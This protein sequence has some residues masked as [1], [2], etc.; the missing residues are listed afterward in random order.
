MNNTY[1]KKLS[2]FLYDN[3]N[4]EEN[5]KENK[6]ESK[7]LTDNEINNKFK[8]RYYFYNFYKLKNI[9]FFNILIYIEA[10]FKVKIDRNKLIDKI[11]NKKLDD[12]KIY[13]ELRKHTNL[14]D[15]VKIEKDLYLIKHINNKI[16]KII[17]TIIKS[18]NNLYREI[19]NNIFKRIL[20]IGTEREE[21]LNK[22]EDIFKCKAL[23]LN[24]DEGYEHY[25]KI[26]DKSRIIIYDGLNFPFFDN[27]FDLVTI[28][29]VLHHIPEDNI[30]IF[31]KNLSKITKRIFISDNNISDENIKKFIEIQH[32]VYEGVLYPNKRS[33][34]NLNFNL[35]ILINEL[36][37]NNF[38]IKI[39]DS[40][41]DHMFGSFNLYA[42]KKI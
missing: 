34:I 38:E 20:D 9:N 40:I 6:K 1:S 36:N 14:D 2:F 35:N 39:I 5:K 13:H 25:E 23:G 29:A 8:N 32:E 42:I 18:N 12:A 11:K 22:L 31:I 41:K 33:F 26:K 28:F 3:K 10:N 21:F 4:K 19:N 30:K 37:N 16:K 7:I 17:N 15:I 27:E 24:I